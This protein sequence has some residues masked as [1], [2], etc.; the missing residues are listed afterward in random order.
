MAERHR[1]ELEDQTPNGRLDMNV[2][3]RRA[4][5]I[6]NS[7]GANPGETRRHRVLGVEVNYYLR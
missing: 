1:E 6:H 5:L 2:I 3:G 4:I 7:L